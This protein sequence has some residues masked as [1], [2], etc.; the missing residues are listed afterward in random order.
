LRRRGGGER[1][2]VHTRRRVN[3]A[4]KREFRRDLERERHQITAFLW[5]FSS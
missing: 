1:K 4:E 2:L 5:E 3:K